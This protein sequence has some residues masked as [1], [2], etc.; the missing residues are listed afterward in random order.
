MQ[1]LEKMLFLELT[2]KQF[3]KMADS[4]YYD[5]WEKLTEIEKQQFGLFS[6]K[7]HQI[8]TYLNSSSIPG[9]FNKRAETIEEYNELVEPISPEILSLTRDFGITLKRTMNT[10]FKNAYIR[11]FGKEAFEQKFGDEE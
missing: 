6:N 11:I 10:D 7:I 2:N 1:A 8:W 4:Q 3:V 9:A 5:T